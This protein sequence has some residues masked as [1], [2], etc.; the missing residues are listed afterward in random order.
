MTSKHYNALA[1]AF[2]N[3]R[4]YAEKHSELEFW[5]KARSIIIDA[6]QS[7]NPRFDCQR[8]I[9]TTEEPKP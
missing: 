4:P 6:L 2:R 1:E 5:R 8:F 3:T 7:D 9:A